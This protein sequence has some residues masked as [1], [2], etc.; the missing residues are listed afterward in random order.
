MRREQV[1]K[2]CANAPLLSGMTIK[3]K[4]STENACMWICKDYAEEASGSK[5]C[6]VAR[7]KEV[8]LADEFISVFRDACD[9]KFAK[10]GNCGVKLPTAK[11]EQKSASSEPA[12]ATSP[13]TVAIEGGSGEDEG[14]G[15]MGT[16]GVVEEVDYDED[17]YEE[18][19]DF[20]AKMTIT[21]GFASP[22][23][24]VRDLHTCL[25]GM[26]LNVCLFVCSLAGHL[27]VA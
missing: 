25:V 13:V 6:F 27:H 26:I 5:E 17:P 2:V 15:P 10:G 12:G 22:L 14:A 4:P 8:A 23:K 21:E 11:G 16:R 20:P 24:P 19:A 7:F 9:G 1:L 3:K 18:L